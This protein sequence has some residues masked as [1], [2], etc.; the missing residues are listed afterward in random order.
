MKIAGLSVIEVDESSPSLY[1]GKM[2]SMMR[3]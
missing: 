2:M 3:E 1:A